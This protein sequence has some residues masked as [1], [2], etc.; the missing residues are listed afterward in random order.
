MEFKRMSRTSLACTIGLGLALTVAPMQ[1]QSG[2]TTAAHGAEVYVAQKC[3]LCHSIAGKGNPRGALDDVGS[4]LT[5]DEI[6]QWIVD[7]TGMTEKTKAARK[8]V[9]RNYKLSV[10]DLAALVAYLESLKAPE[11]P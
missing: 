10:E 8:P 11:A 5:P 4:R 9:M 1:A 2:A 7:A 3:A 6:R